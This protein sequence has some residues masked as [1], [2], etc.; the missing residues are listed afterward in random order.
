[1][2]SSTN[3]VI[4][5]APSLKLANVTVPA[6]RLA[7]ANVK[8]PVL[9]PVADVVANWNWSALSSHPKNALSSSPLSITIPASPDAEPVD[10][11]P[12]SN[13]LSE[14]VVLVEETVVVVPLTVKSPAN[15]K[16]VAP[17]FVTPLKAPPVNV[18]VPSVIDQP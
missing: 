6:L 15:T 1:M 14:I 12:S 13:S 11:V 16:L 7:S 18:A 5:T 9:E 8:S 17:M 10:P 4:V 3:A 2:S